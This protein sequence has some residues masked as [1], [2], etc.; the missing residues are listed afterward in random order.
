MQQYIWPNFVSYRLFLVIIGSICLWGGLISCGQ[1]SKSQFIEIRQIKSGRHLNS[2]V[3]LHGKITKKVPFLGTGAYQLDDGT[4][5]ILVLTQ[6][7]LPNQGEKIS[8][9]GKVQYESIVIEGEE[10]G[11]YYVLEQQRLP[12]L[13]TK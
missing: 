6:N 11:E 4:G 7:P 13:P 1:V 10:L 3:D 12:L 2:Q 9:H 5:A 8:I